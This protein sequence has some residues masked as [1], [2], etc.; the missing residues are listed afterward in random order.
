[1]TMMSGLDIYRTL[2]SALKLARKTETKDLAA[3]IATLGIAFEA[4]FGVSGLTLG[5]I[6]G[7]RMVLALLG[8]LTSQVSTAGGSPT[9]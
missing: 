6:L 5:L 2:S 7:A 9:V 3:V 4:C 8:R 1:M